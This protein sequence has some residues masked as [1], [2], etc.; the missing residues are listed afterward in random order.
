MRHSVFRKL[1][2][3]GFVV[4]I[5]EMLVPV[6]ASA[7]STKYHVVVG[8]FLKTSP[9]ESMRFFPQSIVVHQGDTL[10]FTS[11]SFHT[12]TLLPLGQS[13]DAWT[14]TYAN[15]LTDDPWALLQSDADDAPGTYVIPGRVA[16]PTDPTCGQKGQP[17]CAFDGSGGPSDGVLNSGLPFGGPIDFSVAITAPVG[18]TIWAVCLVHPAMRMMIQVVADGEATPSQD[19]LDASKALQLHTDGN[20]AAALDGRFR[21]KAATH[22]A[23]DGTTVWDAWAGVD[24]R[25]VALY[26][27][28]P[29]TL[30]IK[31]GQRVQW[32]FDSLSF[33]FHTVTMPKTRAKEISNVFTPMCESASGEDSPPDSQRPPFCADP[34]EL[35]IELSDQ[36]IPRSGDGVV[37]GPKDFETS[38]V[39]GS[40]APADF[41]Y[42]LRF[43]ERSPS[44]GFVF[45]CAI[46]TFMRQTVVVR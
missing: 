2:L 39:R 6:V 25:H 18:S 43:A 28:Y 5:S 26:G 36:L 16:L 9:A 40:A 24:N 44:T 32:H 22:V 13:P 29:A 20:S 31:K 38:G 7:A 19:Q 46:H 8:Q 27:I 3:V 30:H 21:A 12:A 4:L 42:Q 11:K 35:E 14:S 37:R 1:A 10:R 45:L 33:E 17:V 41:A 23:S 34:A 15:W